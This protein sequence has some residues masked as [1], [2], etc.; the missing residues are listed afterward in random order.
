MQKTAD[1][2]IKWSFYLLFF[3][4]PLA[5]YSGSFELFEY[6]KMML[7]YALTVIIVTCWIIKTI[8]AKKINFKKTYLAIPLGLYLVSHL[9]SSLF[10]IDL[11]TSIWGYYSRFH[12]GLLATISYLLLYF[13]AVSNLKKADVLRIFYFTLA[14]GSIVS[15][16]GILE[17][18]GSSP[19]CYFITGSGGVD[20][21]IQD[22]KNRVFATLGQPNWM[23]A[24]LNIL[25]LLSIGFVLNADKF[26]NAF[27][28]Y[29]FYLLPAIFFV[30][31]LF[32]KSRSGILGLI[33]GLA[34]FT[35][36]FVY[37]N[38][39]NL[40]L[41]IGKP[42]LILT[43]SL[44][45]LTIVFG[46]PFAQT[47]K[48]SLESLISSRKTEQAKPLPKTSDGYIDIGISES[49]DIRNIVW[50][51]ALKIWERYPL[52]GSGVETFAYSYY[53]D[54][55]VEH[56]MVSE[57]DFLYNKAHNEYLN[58]L[59]TT[60]IVGMIAYLTILFT[61]TIWFVRNLRNSD[62]ISLSLF[63]AWVTILVTNFFG[64]SVVII[65][66]FFFLIP[67]FSFILADVPEKETQ[68][69]SQINALSWFLIA[70]TIVIA[71]LTLSKLWTMWQADRSFAYG[72]N[73]DGI[74][75][76]QIAYRYL[77]DAVNGNPAEPTIRDELAYN[78]SVLALAFFKQA[79]TSAEARQLTQ[80][81]INN[82]NIVLNESPAVLSFWKTRTRLF[83]NLSEIDKKY[84]FEALSAIKK[85]AELAPTDAKVN[86]NYG[87]L[88]G[89]TG[90]I[91]GGIAVLKRTVDMKP[92][93]ADARYALG[94]FYAQKGQKDKAREQMEFMLKRIGKDSRA[95]K[96]L[97][98]NK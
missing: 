23:A 75:E 18:F 50:K 40:R 43:L 16:W 49:G 13:A 10:S 24:Y 76:F 20:C 93:Y 81:A 3:L 7:T 84:I 70:I 2:I 22:V 46:L 91:N 28:K 95:V 89:Q 34:V 80:E 98:E 51:G 32:T 54:R 78:Q 79:S 53:K 56:N 52:F 83:Y 36:G 26:K 29:I 67:A 45:I 87:F 4:I 64:F 65:G 90:D 62:L 17:H 44:G 42:F 74:Q 33:A 69:K 14:S 15:F 12:E 1:I 86:Y 25:I 9:I 92:D 39:Q 8:T 38:R 31:L 94:I 82:S 97:E 63:S 59:A 60:G 30:A 41:S 37:K 55:P 72:K 11:H 27:L 35:L 66:L 77:I 73:L 19:S 21:W 68:P 5:F 47:E 61:F 88:L 6:N 48:L 96:W 57:W 58:I 85:A 71:L